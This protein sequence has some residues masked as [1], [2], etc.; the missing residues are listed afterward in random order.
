MNSFRSVAGNLVRA[1]ALLA[2]ALLAGFAS[3][4]QARASQLPADDQAAGICQVVQSDQP[5]LL[6]QQESSSSEPGSTVT[7]DGAEAGIEMSQPGFNPFGQTATM[8]GQ[9]GSEEVTEP[10][11]S[12][13][14]VEESS[15][16]DNPFGRT[17]TMGGKS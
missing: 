9:P 1:M 17:V 6:A 5:V 2:L 3:S 11:E 15:S 8:R 16:Q 14:E 7:T 10:I 4:S 13:E 12:S